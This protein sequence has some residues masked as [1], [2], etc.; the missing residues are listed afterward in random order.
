MVAIFVAAASGWADIWVNTSPQEAEVVF[1]AAVAVVVGRARSVGTSVGSA[2]AAAV[3]AK[4]LVRANSFEAV[5]V[6]GAVVR[7]LGA[8][9]VPFAA[10][11]ATRRTLVS[12]T[13]IVRA[14]GFA[15]SVAIGVGFFGAGG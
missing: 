9:R 1:G 12:G 4:D 6:G 14:T 13:T 10:G 2:V 5:V 8:T 3:D 7:A 11:D 15:E